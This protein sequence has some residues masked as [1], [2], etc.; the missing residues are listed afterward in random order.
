M[1]PRPSRVVRPRPTVPEAGG[2][3]VIAPRSRY[4]AVCA[5]TG[6]G[7]SAA[8]GLP[9]FRGQDGLWALDPELERALDGSQVPG[10]VEVMWQAWGT[11]YA[12]AVAAGPTAA[13]QA[14]TAAGVTVITQN[15]DT[16]HSLAGSADPVELHGS[17][18]IACCTSDSR[19]WRSTV[20]VDPSDGTAAPGG[21]FVPGAVDGA[22]G[23]PA[24]PRCGAPARQDVVLFGEAI[25]AGA[26]T[27][28]I[29]SVR[30][31]DLFLAVGTSGVVAPASGLA[32]L[33]RR[34]GACCVNVVLDPDVVLNP[35]FH[36]QVIG[37]A[38]VELPA[39]LAS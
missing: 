10:N 37:D 13:H 1:R 33:A 2:L 27:A 38:Q 15:V 24:C 34:A 21:V 39:W 26:L 3:A 30:R 8:A 32:G 7:I 18:G 28:A 29:D 16:L 6:A 11:I 22:D 25:P 17:A 20:S 5:L 4:R 9:T 19:H 14:L 23:V 36:A 12:A 35:A 31:C